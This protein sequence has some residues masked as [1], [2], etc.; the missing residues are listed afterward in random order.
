MRLID[1]EEVANCYERMMN[2]LD[3]KNALPEQITEF[4]VAREYLQW[5]SYV[6][7]NAPTVDAVTYEEWFSTNCETCKEYDK[8][9][10]CCPKF[11]G[12]IKQ[13]LKDFEENNKIVRCKDCKFAQN[14]RYNSRVDGKNS[15]LCEHVTT[16][17]GRY[18]LKVFRNAN[19]FCSY[20]ERKNND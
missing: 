2:I 19:D 6:I 13:T 20:G 8:E 1:A 15:V 11:R 4:A 9:K 18:E 3:K 16:E 7:N 14:N 10:H 17:D 5:A 12:V